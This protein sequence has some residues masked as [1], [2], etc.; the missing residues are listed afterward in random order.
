MEPIW[1]VWNQD[2][3]TTGQKNTDLYHLL[4]TMLYVG[5]AKYPNY[6]LHL[7]HHI[8]HP[9][10]PPIIS[11]F[12]LSQ[13]GQPAL[14]HCV[15]PRHFPPLRCRAVW[16]SQPPASRSLGFLGAPEPEEGSAPGGQGA[17]AM[18]PLTPAWSGTVL[19]WRGK[20]AAAL[21][22]C[23]NNRQTKH[24]VFYITDSWNG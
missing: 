18:G 12:G 7:I 2:I 19:R 16:V 23:G 10:C 24:Q 5:T 4:D 3:L 22:G 15:H 13:W 11:L 17:G 14:P 8:F 1:Q 21:T 6:I 9:L 20:V